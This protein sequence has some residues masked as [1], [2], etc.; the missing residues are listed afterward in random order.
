MTVQYAIVV[1]PAFDSPEPIEAVR[2]AFDPH[3]ALLPAHITLVFPFPASADA[4]ALRTHLD[5]T[6]SGVSSFDVTLAAPSV[7]HDA[8]LFLRVD[9]G[10][11]R[12]IALH[13][14]LYTGPLAL[15]LSSTHTYEPHVTVGHLASRDAIPEALLTARKDIP[16]G[17]CAH[18][19]GVSL[20]RLEE[21]AGHVEF[22]LP[23]VPGDDSRSIAM[24]SAPNE[25]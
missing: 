25:R 10:R 17:S 5:A 15:H 2:R 1:F 24:R 14:A 4:A 16:A 6:L 7:E 9:A 3:A 22:T 11:Q 19:S 20:F 8:Y 18:V 23:L 21:G 13:D 12:L